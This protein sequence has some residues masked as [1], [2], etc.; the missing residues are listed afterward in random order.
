MLCEKYPVGP[1]VDMTGGPPGQGRGAAVRIPSSCAYRASP[2]HCVA[3][4]SRCP[5]TVRNG[6]ARPAVKEPG[7]TRLTSSPAGRAPPPRT[8]TSAPSDGPTQT[9]SVEPRAPGRGPSR[10]GST[11]SRAVQGDQ[12]PVTA[13][14][15]R[16]S[17]VPVGSAEGSRHE[18]PSRANGRVRCRASPASPRAP[19]V[20][21]RRYSAASPSAGPAPV[22]AAPAGRPHNAEAPS[23]RARAVPHT[24]FAFTPVFPTCGCRMT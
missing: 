21:A 4:P 13:S 22:P 15:V 19:G 5:E 14:R 20:R 2:G 9:G 24:R 11:G 3:K 16:A 6:Y 1:G 23:T 18:T 8:R 10:P 12:R 7:S 17:T